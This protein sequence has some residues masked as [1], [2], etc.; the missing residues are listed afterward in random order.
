MKIS[1]VLN[2]K[3]VEAQ[4]PMTGFSLIFYGITAVSA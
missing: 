2:G 4:I 1:L 3:N